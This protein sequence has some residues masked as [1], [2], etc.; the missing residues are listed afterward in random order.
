M[1]GRQDGRQDGRKEGW[2]AGIP[3]GR[4]EGREVGCMDRRRNGR[5]EV[6]AEFIWYWGD[7]ENKRNI[8]NY[9]I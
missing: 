6:F 8:T 7:R 2:K 1:E 4:Q 9:F 3:E 5:N